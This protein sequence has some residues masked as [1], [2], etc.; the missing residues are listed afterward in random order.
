ML[1]RNWGRQY[2]V[3]NTT[4]TGYSLIS[5]KSVNSTGVA[6]YQFNNP[7]GMPWQI[8]PI[9]SRWQMQIGIRYNF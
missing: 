9:A 6:T 2:F 8:D 3:P 7:S 4:N 5:V 1:N